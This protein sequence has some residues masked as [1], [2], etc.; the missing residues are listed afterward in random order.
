MNITNQRI[1]AFFKEHPNLEPETI[2]LRFIDIMESLHETMNSSM[3]NTMV[4]D[5]LDK[6]KQINTKIDHVAEKVNKITEDTKT[7]FSLK[8]A[9]FKKEY[10][11]ELNMVL[12]CNVSDKIAPLVKEQNEALFNKTNAMI[13]EVIPK[14]ET[15]LSD[16][17]ERMVGQFRE[18]VN[19]DTQAM[20]ANSMDKETFTKY[21]SDFNHN[22]SSIISASQGLLTEAIARSGEK[23]ENKINYTPY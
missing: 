2:I 22:M 15:V 6:L 16:S 4:I 13:Q 20:F 10:L 12:T 11:A 19:R 14:N 7:Q 5:M 18:S 9:E 8:M 1:L 3:N 17:I 21:L 23:L